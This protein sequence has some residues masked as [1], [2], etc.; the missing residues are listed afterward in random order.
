[1]V[2]KNLTRIEGGRTIANLNTDSNLVCYTIDH[3]CDSGKHTLSGPIVDRLHEFEKLG[4]E[5][6]ELKSLIERYHAYKLMAHSTFG[7][8][9]F[10]YRATDNLS[11]KELSNLDIPS[12]YPKIMMAIESPSK[13]GA[14]IGEIARKAFDDGLNAYRY[15]HEDIKSARVIF[16]NTHDAPKISLVETNKSLPKIKNVI[17]NNPATIVFWSDGDKTVVKAQNGEPYDPE[18]GL[19]MAI[20]KKALGNDRRYYD[21]F[22]K[23]LGRGQKHSTPEQFNSEVCHIQKLEDLMTVEEDNKVNRE[24]AAYALDHLSKAVNDP[25]ATKANLTCAMEEAIKCVNA[26]LENY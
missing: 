24:L 3:H 25:K 6:E 9:A 10:N 20:S 2:N 26:I 13:M 8:C 1:M 12:L 23:H 16:E 5:P 22:Q 21:E 15:I 4:Y 14:L 11:L 19:A 18:K 7:K 17:F